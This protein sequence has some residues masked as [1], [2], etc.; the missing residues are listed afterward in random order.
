MCRLFGLRS[1][2]HAAPFALAIPHS[3]GSAQQCAQQA[4][5]SET[6]NKDGGHTNH[7]RMINHVDG[8]IHPEIKVIKDM[9]AAAVVVASVG[10][11]LLGLVMIFDTVA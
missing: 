2:N 6:T 9:A 5:V 7:I 10:V 3:E 4:A 11:F 1:S 8:R